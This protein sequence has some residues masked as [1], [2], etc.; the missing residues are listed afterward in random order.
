MLYV[1][2]SG[3]FFVLIAAAQ[4]TRTVFG[5]TAR[6]GSIDIPVWWSAIACL[7]TSALAFWA[8]RTAKGAA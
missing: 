1:R 3:V 6:V 8:F 2:I 4:L 7:V 5:W